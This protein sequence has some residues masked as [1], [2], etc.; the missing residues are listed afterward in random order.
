MV[1]CTEIHAAK[2]V[3]RKKP[4]G[5][6]SIPINIDALGPVRVFVVFHLSPFHFTPPRKWYRYGFAS[7]L[8]THFF[9]M[10]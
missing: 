7:H 4:G 1:Q 9:L 8:R 2:N 3:L 10:G 5:C 6:K